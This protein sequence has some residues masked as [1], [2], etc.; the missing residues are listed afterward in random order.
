MTE[1]EAK[2]R[3]WG[4]SIGITIPKDVLEEEGI[5]PGDEVVFEIK[6]KK[7][8]IWKIFGTVKRKISAQKFKDLARKGWDG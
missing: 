3:Q 8:D 5:L 6:K 7:D 2:A 4:N 1:G